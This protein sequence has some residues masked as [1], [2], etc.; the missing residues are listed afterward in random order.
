MPSRRLPRLKP[1]CRMANRPGSLPNSAIRAIDAAPHE[2]FGACFSNCWT[3]S[4]STTAFDG[5]VTWNAPASAM[6]SGCASRSVDGR[7]CDTR[8]TRDQEIPVDPDRGRGGLSHGGHRLLA[9]RVDDR[10]ADERVEERPGRDAERIDERHRERAQRADRVHET[11]EVDLSAQPVRLVNPHAQ[12]HPRI[13]RHS[14]VEVELLDLD[15]V[16]DQQHVHVEAG[17]PRQRDVRGSRVGLEVVV[18]RQVLPQLGGDPM[19]E[20]GGGHVQ[21]PVAPFAPIDDESL[22]EVLPGSPVEVLR[23]ADLDADGERRPGVADGDPGVEEPGR[24]IESIQAHADG[25]GRSEDRSCV[26]T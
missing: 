9:D 20:V 24:E 10:R 25:A 6:P 21:R 13:R 22:V 5:S 14:D 12:L 1:A 7:P 23:G 19:G 3:P 2:I 17:P 8:D 15:R 26:E 18:L 11:C 4:T 16:I